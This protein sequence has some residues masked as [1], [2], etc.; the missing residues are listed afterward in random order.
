MSR[1]GSV[2]QQVAEDPATAESAVHQL[3]RQL[4]ENQAGQDATSDVDKIILDIELDGARYLAIRC[5]LR[6]GRVPGADLEPTTTTSR[7]ESHPSLSPREFEIARM[8][9]KGY[10]NKTIASVLAISTWTVSS[11][12]RRIYTKL[13]VTSRAAMVAKLLNEAPSGE[14]RSLSPWDQG[15]PWPPGEGSPAGYRN[16]MERSD[17]SPTSRPPSAHASLP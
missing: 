4:I 10:A 5:S 3:I 7:Q 11:H 2:R 8:V 1:H 17:L 9:S 12:L 13:D 16:R 15:A 14:P 6:S